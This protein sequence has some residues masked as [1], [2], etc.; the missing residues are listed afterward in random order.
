[1]GW[2]PSASAK[3]YGSLAA[4]QTLQN[5]APLLFAATGFEERREGELRQSED[6][7]ETPV[8]AVR[9]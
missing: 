9:V 5:P 6:Q 7:G 2:N 4:P 8:T 3:D 1:V